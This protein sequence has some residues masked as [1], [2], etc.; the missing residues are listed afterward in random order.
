MYQSAEFEK[1]RADKLSQ[2]IDPYLKSAESG[3][4][5]LRRMLRNIAERLLSKKIPAN[6]FDESERTHTTKGSAQILAQRITEV[7]DLVGYIF[8]DLEEKKIDQGLLLEDD[9]IRKQEELRSVKADILTLKREK[10]NIL[11]DIV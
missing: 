11:N 8:K 6:Q 7:T 10:E 4:Y 9:M 3:I 2:Q 1:K 5:N